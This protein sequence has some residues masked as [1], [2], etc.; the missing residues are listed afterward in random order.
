MRFANGIFEPLWNQKYVDHVQ[1]TVAEDIGIEGR[2]AY[3]DESGALRDMVQNHMMQLL[4]LT[5]MEAPVAFEADEVRNEKVKV[6][7]AVRPIPQE[8]IG[9]HVVRGQYAAGSVSGSKTPPYRE[10]KGV[11]SGSDTETYVAIRLFIDNWRWAGVPF[12]L[13]TGKRLPK[14]VTEIAIQFKDVPYLLFGDGSSDGIK[15]NVL[16]LRIQPDEGISLTMTSK[17]PGTVITLRPVVMDFRYGTSFGSEPPEAYERLLLDAIIGDSTL[18]TRRDEVEAAWQFINEILDAWHTA[19]P[20]PLHTYEAG[21][22][23]PTAANTLI[24]RWR[25]L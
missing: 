4:C 9:E 12:Y 23:G 21:T 19:S 14:R 7:H 11:E 22:W 17:V 10:E 6:L 13:R 15:A 16:A 25:R 3:Y 18:F 20:P 1:I 2:G 24:G 5:A 8:E